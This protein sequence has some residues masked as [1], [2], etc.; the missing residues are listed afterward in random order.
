[1]K[2][3]AQG[4]ARPATARGLGYRRHT[5]GFVW[6]QAGRNL[7]PVSDGSGERGAADEVRAGAAAHAGRAR[8]RTPRCTRCR[9]LPRP[10]RP[11]ELSGGEQQRVAVVLATASAP[12]VLLADEPTGELDAASG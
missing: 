9:V 12:R 10:G 6:Q 2:R 1:M 8:R 7:L 11:A 3:G 4:R 5:V